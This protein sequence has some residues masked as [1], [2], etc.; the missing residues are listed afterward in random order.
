MVSQQLFDLYL[1]IIYYN[2]SRIQDGS[3]IPQETV[4]GLGQR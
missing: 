4:Y 3:N 1:N 2:S